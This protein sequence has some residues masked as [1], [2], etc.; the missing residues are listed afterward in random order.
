[1]LDTVY[2]VCDH[3]AI[4]SRDRDFYESAFILARQLL[5]RFHI[6]LNR[7]LYIRKS[8]FF[9]CSLRPAAGQT[10]TLDAVTFLGV[11]ENDAIVC[12]ESKGTP[13]AKI[14]AKSG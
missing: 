3:N 7:Y 10:R 5:S 1:M 4:R 14:S 2:S 6:L 12:H 13:F 11:A 8:F 9:G